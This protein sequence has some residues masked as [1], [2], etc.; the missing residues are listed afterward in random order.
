MG[1]WSHPEVDRAIAQVKVETDPARRDDAIRR[2]LVI[3]NRELPV[4]LAVLQELEARRGSLQQKLVLQEND[5]VDGSGALVWQKAGSSYTIESL[6][7]R[8]ME[9]SDNTAANLLV[10]SIGVDTLNRHAQALMG[11]GVPPDQVYDVMRTPEGLDRAFAKL[12]SIRDQIVWWEAGAQPVQLLADA[13]VA[14]TM[15][16]NGRLFAAP[17][18]GE[19]RFD[20][21][22]DRV[23]LCGS[24]AMIRETAAM[25]DAAG[26]TEGSNANPGQY[27]IERAFVD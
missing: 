5:K 26:M 17:L 3:A 20:P 10:R 7:K 8:M 18:A 15:S 19:P 25:L 14:M 2:A 6:L 22:H 27:V 1:R 21:E 9:Q 16:Y 23:M 12:D 4:A 13:E 11:D 24:T